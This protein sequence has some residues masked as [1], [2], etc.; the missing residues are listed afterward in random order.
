MKGVKCKKV[1]EGIAIWV[2]HLNDKTCTA[3]EQVK[4]SG[5]IVRK[6]CM[7]LPYSVFC[8]IYLSKFYKFKIK[9]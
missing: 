9:S 2:W 6:Y 7:L 5:N 8:F 3:V 4:E 1:E